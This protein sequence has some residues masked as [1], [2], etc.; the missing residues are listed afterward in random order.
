VGVV[1]GTGKGMGG[2][3]EGREE[4]MG[5]EKRTGGDGIGEGWGGG[6][7]RWCGCVWVRVWVILYG[8]IG[9]VG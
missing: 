6:K 1:K 5:E 3:W 2:G 4:E 7:R 8:W 9:R